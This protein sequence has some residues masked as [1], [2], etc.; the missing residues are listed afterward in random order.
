MDFLHLKEIT[1]IY[2]DSLHRN[3][4]IPRQKN[5]LV[6]RDSFSKETVDMLRPAL[7]IKVKR[8][9]AFFFGSNSLW[10]FI[11]MNVVAMGSYLYDLHVHM[12]ITECDFCS[13]KNRTY[14]VVVLMSETNNILIATVYM[15]PVNETLIF[16]T[17]FLMEYLFWSLYVLWNETTGW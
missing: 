2:P 8:W 12:V 14:H 17:N 9:S 7:S 4:I 15:I 1:A 16:V 5:L 6:M 3:C 10:K 11:K 13:E